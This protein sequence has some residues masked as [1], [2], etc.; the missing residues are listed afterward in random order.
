MR[1]S[2]LLVGLLISGLIRAQTYVPP[3]DGTLSNAILNAV[4]GDV[5]E[6]VSGGS[7]TESAE[8]LFG[9]IEDKTLTIQVENY[10]DKPEKAILN[11]LTPPDGI[12]TVRF[13]DL[14]KN[15]TFIVRG[16]EFD[17]TWGG[18]ANAEYGITFYLG[19]VPVPTTVNKVVLEN[20]YFHD[21]LSDVIAAGNSEMRGNLIVDS[22][23]VS[24]VIMERTGTSVYYK[25]CGANHISVK[26]STFNTILSY[27]MRVSGPVESNFPLNTPSVQIDRTTWYNIGTVDQ[28]EIIQCEKGPHLGQWTVTNSI[29]VKHLNK[30]RTAIN[31]KET[32]PEAIV[33]HICLWDVGK[34]TW[35]G[36]SHNVTVSDT[37]NVDPQFADPDNGDF[38][39]P[40]GSE[41]LIFADDGGAIG[42]LRWAANAPTPVINTTR[43]NAVEFGLFQN[44]PNPFNPV[45]TISFGL[46][47]SGPVQLAIYD[48]LGNQVAQ[49]VNESLSAGRH[50]IDFAGTN[51]PSGIYF[52]RLNAE[53]KTV[54]KKMT[55]LK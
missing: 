23:F 31:I 38:T 18:E 49:P 55:L 24:D 7:Y 2:I 26:N 37:I 35:S 9:L 29:F 22:T 47:E 4:D 5:L 51:L 46:G 40:E 44:Y 50:S 15:A 20:C 28:R 48:I 19:E 14:G 36:S 30:D 33:S 27:G 39:L 12:S 13:F 42:D 52:Y 8:Y 34:R 54:V 53:G 41:L 45:T 6:L 32:V 21:F 10:Q 1:R 43:V 3:G 25:Y 11:I 17:G 16:V